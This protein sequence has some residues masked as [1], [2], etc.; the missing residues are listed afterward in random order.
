MNRAVA[1]DIGRFLTV[2]VVFIVLLVALA[3]LPSAGTEARPEVCYGNTVFGLDFVDSGMSQDLFHRSALAAAD[4]EAMAISFLPGAGGET[5]SPAIAQTS[6]STVTATSLG[7]F[8]SNFQFCPSINLGAAPVGMGQFGVPSPVTTAKFSG[9]SLIFPE[10]TIEGNLRA[11]GNFSEMVDTGITLPPA[12]AI[13]AYDK[14]RG[15]T[16]LEENQS[17]QGFSAREKNL[18][19]ILSGH[20]VDFVSTTDEINNTSIVDRLWRN[21]HQ[22][23][24]LNYL[25]EGEAARPVW[26]APVEHPYELI[27]C[28][29]AADAIKHS[30][31]LTRPGKYLT[32]A[33][34]SL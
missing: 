29:V 24:A 18:P 20:T 6:S 1:R 12:L 25:Y 17:A 2:Q 27:D 9:H 31:E 10:M 32:R 33:Y 19:V 34:W 14:V 13:N 16:Y 8:N 21:S 23:N 5:V 15:L 4:Q 22:A 3:P 26:I 30:L 7:F 11:N 28:G